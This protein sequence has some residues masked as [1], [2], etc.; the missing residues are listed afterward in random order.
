MPTGVIKIGGGEGNNPSRVLKEIATRHDRGESWVLVH[1]VSSQM[2]SLCRAVGIRPHYVLSPSGFRSRY[3]G[4]EEMEL[5]EAAALAET[6]RL[7]SFL[8]TL[9]VPAM[10][11]D[12][13]TT[14]FI[15]GETKN[16]IRELS[17]EKVRVLHGNRSG[18]VLGVDASP[19]NWMLKRGYL[20]VVPPLGRDMETGR[21]MNIDGD[22][23]AAAIAGEIGASIMVLLTNVPGLM[24]DPEDRATLIPEIR[25]NEWKEAEAV[26][27]GNMKRKVLACRE[28]LERGVSE[29][30]ISDSRVELPLASATEGGGTRFCRADCTVIAV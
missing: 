3:V 30:V 12:P 20:P 9:G 28:A 7:C 26:A 1:G 8:V 16:C 18:K 6:S 27:R 24:R 23:A 19:L 2:D 25:S 17:G 15:T 29:A 21:G 14:G 4:D 11:L 10:P 5:F 13:V 22:R